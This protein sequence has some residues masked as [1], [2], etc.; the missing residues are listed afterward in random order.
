MMDCQY[1]SLL[2]D[3]GAGHA[4]TDPTFISNAACSVTEP[5]RFVLDRDILSGPFNEKK[6]QCSTQYQG[7]KSVAGYRGFRE[8]FL[9]IRG[10]NDTLGEEAPSQRAALR[11][12]ARSAQRDGWWCSATS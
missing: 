9:S 6:L 11:R 1:A 7:A 4:S 10:A 12:L 5:R 8:S 2:M 3:C